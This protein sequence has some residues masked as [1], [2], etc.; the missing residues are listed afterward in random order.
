MH[1]TNRK[2]KIIPTF[3]LINHSLTINSHIFVSVQP[4]DIPS[5]LETP[6]S[7]ELSSILVV[8]ENNLGESADG[9]QSR[10]PRLGGR[11][12]GNKKLP[13]TGLHTPERAR[14][15]SG[16]ADS[17]IF[18]RFLSRTTYMY[19]PCCML[20]DSG[21]CVPGFTRGC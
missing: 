13:Q 11:P 21:L 16:V 5:F 14:Q 6:N 4:I 10:A 2:S 8:R 1:S 18:T 7:Q 12:N 19:T 20:T 9:T 17:A 15:I 3:P